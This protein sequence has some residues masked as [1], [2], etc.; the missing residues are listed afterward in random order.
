MV[1]DCLAKRSIDADLGHYRLP[2]MPD[3]V[4]DAIMDDMVGLASPRA[5]L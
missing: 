3:F 1:T 2:T 5:V 4:V